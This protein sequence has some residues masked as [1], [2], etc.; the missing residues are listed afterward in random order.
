MALVELKYRT[1]DELL[2]AVLSDFKTYE[3]EGMIDPQELIKVAQRVNTD[4]SIKINKNRQTILEIEKGRV[5]M[6]NDY[7]KIN[8]AFI[9]SE[10]VINVPHLQ[11]VQTEDVMVLPSDCNNPSP[12][13]GS[14]FNST[15]RQGTVRMTQCCKEYQVVQYF[16]SSNITYKKLH[17]LTLTSGPGLFDDCPNKHWQSDFTG[18]IK[19]GWLYTNVESGKLY[20]NYVSNMEDEDGNLLVLDDNVINEYYE[21]AMKERILENLLMEGE[22]VSNKLNYIAGKRRTARIEAKTR[23]GMYEFDELEQMWDM[24]RQAM[25]K[26]YYYQFI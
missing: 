5:R 26:K 8:L 13:L 7:F 17:K 20:L 3:Q 25:Y 23:A 21:Y 2:S 15:C 12:I 16:H 19:D 4:L 1:F 18:Y 10:K 24:N 6:P 11:G 9:L 22:D 14:D